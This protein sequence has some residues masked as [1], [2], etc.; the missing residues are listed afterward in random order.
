MDKLSIGKDYKRIVT[1][2]NYKELFI[3]K[4]YQAG[5]FAYNIKEMLVF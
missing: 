3:I 1:A 4:T 2:K 5:E